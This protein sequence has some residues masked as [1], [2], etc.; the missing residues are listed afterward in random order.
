MHIS[1]RFF[2]RGVR[3]WWGKAVGAQIGAHTR[4]YHEGFA[5]S[6]RVPAG[7]RGQESK[8]GASWHLT[9]HYAA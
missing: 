4:G 2:R 1:L 7:L 3:S 8:V 9:R 6:A 5:S